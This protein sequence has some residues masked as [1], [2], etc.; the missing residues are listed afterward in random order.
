MPEQDELRRTPETVEAA[1]AEAPGVAPVAETEVAQP[2]PAE[3][4]IVQLPS[5]SPA[6]TAA[7]EARAES[8]EE[9]ILR[10]VSEILVEDLREVYEKLPV[11]RQREFDESGDELVR[12][13]VRSAQAGRLTLTGIHEPVLAWLQQLRRDVTPEFMMQTAKRG[14]ERLVAYFGLHPA[15]RH[16]G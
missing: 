2:T 5:A 8:E 4:E 16:A 9:R 3:A 12:E 1:G 14:Y 10:E 6:E 11:D 13:I 7:A 15:E